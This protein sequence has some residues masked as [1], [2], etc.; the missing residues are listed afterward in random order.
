MATAPTNSVIEHLRR[1]A[2]GDGAGLDDAELLG[3]FIERHDEAALAALV[4]LHGPMVWGVCRRLLSHHDAED[5]FQAA[6]LV[7]V[8]KAASVVPREMVGNWLFGVAHRTALLARRTATR[9]RAREVQVMV[10]PDAEAVQQD[11][12]ADVQPLLDEEL[13]RLPNIYRA[14][15]VLC[16]L[17]GRTRKEVARQLGVPEGTVAGRLSRA[18]A[19][20]AKR[21]TERGVTL[22]GG[23]LAVVLA[24]KVAS[25]GV[26]TSVVSSTIKAASLYAAGQAAATG[27]ISAEVAALAEGVLKS[28]F[29]TK[30]KIA[31][32]V[33]LIVVAL[34]GGAGL[35][36]P[37][38][39]GEATTD[40]EKQ[41][42]TLK[43]ADEPAGDK[44]GKTAELQR[45][46]GGLE[47][48]VQ[49]LTSEL[50]A[51]KKE[52]KTLTARPPA[53]TEINMFQLR[54]TKAD[55]VAKTLEQ[56]FKTGSW[57]G[58]IATHL[59]TNTLIV[60]GSS[61]DL[62]LVEAIV[63]RLEEKPVKKAGKTEPAKGG[64]S[65]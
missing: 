56:L 3:C 48:Q 25:A 19:M 55:E 50:T 45:R 2:L 58:R 41:V 57:K 9:R 8:K 62:S 15:L 1:I 30:W 12:W 24:Q 49:S 51:L 11:R 5:A 53:K 17:E 47:K 20:L 29:L 64:Q 34:G 65:K 27:V 18:R 4:K 28:M 26:P 42:L 61:T 13:S 35:I 37:T 54:N 40:K 46:I 60:E 36:Y 21:L 16:D 44:D 43:R 23:S 38:Q 10:M 52:V 6:F 32:A 31:T 7:L 59:P 22:S 33:V 63:A 39:A 14:V